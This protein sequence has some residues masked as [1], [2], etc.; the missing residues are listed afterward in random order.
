MRIIFSLLILLAAT[1]KPV[2]VLA[3]E[4]I[5]LLTTPQ[6]SNSLSITDEF[7]PVEQAYILDVS[8]DQPD[9]IRLSWQI[10]EGY[11]LYRH[12]FAFQLL[13]DNTESIT[14]Q[15]AIKPGL[16]KTDEYFGDVEV[17]YNYANVDLSGIPKQARLQ[18]T[19]TSQ[20]CAD[21]GLCYPPR[22]QYYQIDGE[23]LRITA[24]DKPART[25][26]A[27]QLPEIKTPES[28]TSS[29]AYI[30]LFAI[31]G[32]TILNLMPCVFPVLSLKVLSFTRDKEHSH[33]V[34][35]LVYTLG[36]ISSFVLIA[37]VLISL[38]AAGQAIGW[39]FHL[40]SP[41]FVALLAYLFFTMGLSLSGF[42]ELGGGWMN[43]G[44][45]LSTESGY[46]GSFFTGVLATVVASPCTAPFMGSALGFAATQPPLIA[47]SVF[48][49]LGLGMALPV[50][51]LSCS[52]ALLKHIPKPGQWMERF[53][54]F[55]AFPLYA[56]A[57]WLC[58][59]IGKQTG[60]NGMA[61]VAL[62]CLLVTLAIWF[63]DSSKIKQSISAIC[64]ALAI[65]IVTSP[66]L[67]ASNG[68]NNNDNNW[69]VYSPARLT[70]LRQQRKPIFINITADWCITCLANEKATLGTEAVKQALIK[71]GIT[72][73]KGDW[74]N[75]DPEITALLAQFDRNGI[76]LYLVFPSDPARTVKVLPQ[77][78]TTSTVVDALQDL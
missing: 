42:L 16:K 52:P 36:V 1:L 43:L 44:N 58:W 59:V 53:K 24:I 45:K 78:L 12:A 69:E 60:V 70:E 31:L 48:A 30:L 73:L 22:K 54:E 21:A 72:Y 2:T 3:Q 75:R 39:G 10:T 18:L 40:Q 68:G 62:G 46:S 55:L 61:A 8:F 47:M 77:I 37:A 32:G 20:G 71:N 27:T 49:A 13:D 29:L 4:N 28:Q 50:L 63:W 26:T 14:I 35:G 17:Y 9:Q 67:T 23:Q 5:D 51:I 25:N 11:Y 38:Q 19:V 34:H 7:L 66:L 65:V 76:P 74:T 57:I 64:T 6:L 56:T 33:S 15:T 41:W